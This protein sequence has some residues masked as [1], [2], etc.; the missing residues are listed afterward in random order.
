[1]RTPLRSLTVTPY[2][3]SQGRAGVEATVIACWRRSTVLVT[4][5]VTSR[6]ISSVAG[7]TNLSLHLRGGFDRIEWHNH[8][9]KCSPGAGKQMKMSQSLTSGEQGPDPVLRLLQCAGLPVDDAHVN[10]GDEALGYAL[11]WVVE[12]Y[13]ARVSGEHDVDLFLEL[14]ARPPKDGSGWSRSILSGLKFRDDIPSADRAEMVQE[15]QLV[16]LRRLI[17]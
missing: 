15:A 4:D 16:A 8:L 12:K 9:I 13:L 1:M 5:E 2:V 6:G 3:K 17:G 7:S 14:Y 10:D 11:V